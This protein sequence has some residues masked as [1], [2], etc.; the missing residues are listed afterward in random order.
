MQLRRGEKII[1]RLDAIEDTKGNN[2]DRGMCPSKKYCLAVA[3]PFQMHAL[4]V[5]NAMAVICI[6]HAMSINHGIFSSSP[7]VIHSSKCRGLKK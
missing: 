2:G 4:L 6:L 3:Y 1:D 5:K 7:T